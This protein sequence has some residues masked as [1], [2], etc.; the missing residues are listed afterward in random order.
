MTS[1][2]FVVMAFIAA[3]AIYGWLAVGTVPGWVSLTLL[4]LFLSGVQL[5]I[6]RVISEYVGR[7]YMQGKS[8]PLFIVEKVA[9]SC[10]E[11]G[12]PASG[13]TTGSSSPRILTTSSQ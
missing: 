2:V 13:R 9:G 3:Y 1:L 5:L 12:G 10:R 7:I 8:R 11:T 6:L 4:I